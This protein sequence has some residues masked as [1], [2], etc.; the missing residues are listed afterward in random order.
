MKVIEKQL[1]LLEV[2]FETKNKLIEKGRVISTFTIQNDIQK[3]WKRYNKQE[4]LEMNKYNYRADWYKNK[5]SV[6]LEHGM[7]IGHV[8]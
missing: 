5:F 8:L 2:Q 1:N 7:A 4:N 3:Y 6:N